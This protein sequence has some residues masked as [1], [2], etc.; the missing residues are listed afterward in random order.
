MGQKNIKS[1]SHDQIM[2]SRSTVE[3]VNEYTNNFLETVNTPV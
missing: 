3:K 2:E 1:F